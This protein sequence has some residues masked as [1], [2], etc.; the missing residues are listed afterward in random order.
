[1]SNLHYHMPPLGQKQATHDSLSISRA[2]TQW[3]KNVMSFEVWCAITCYDPSKDDGGALFQG[4]M[5]HILTENN[6]SWAGELYE[7]YFRHESM[8]D[9]EEA[10]NQLYNGKQ[11]QCPKTCFKA[12]VETGGWYRGS[13]KRTSDTTSNTEQVPLARLRWACV[14]VRTGHPLRTTPSRWSPIRTSAKTGST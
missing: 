9:N 3:Y 7:D 2:K 8:W 6:D 14:T 10:E 5:G 1:M 4:M 11:L 13:S 12:R